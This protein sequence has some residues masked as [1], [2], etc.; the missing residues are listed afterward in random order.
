MIRIELEPLDVKDL[1]ELL[2]YAKEQKELNRPDIKGWDDTNWWKLRIDVLVGKLKG[3]H[4]VDSII[5]SS[6]PVIDEWSEEM[7]GEEKWR[8]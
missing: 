6:L 2:E 1:I 7:K 4:G 3:E 5:Q 8:M